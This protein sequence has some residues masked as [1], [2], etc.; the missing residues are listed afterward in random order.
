M[1][2]T[3]SA[4]F[5]R[6]PFLGG[7]VIIT[8][9]ADGNFSVR[10]DGFPPDQYVTLLQDLRSRHGGYYKVEARSWNFRGE[11]RY[12]VIHAISEWSASHV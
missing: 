12:A 1:N 7:S 3:A 10:C 8:D 4:T 6:I 11:V 9:F 2:S 5:S